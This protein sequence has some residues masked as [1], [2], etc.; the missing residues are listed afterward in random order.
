MAEMVSELREEGFPKTLKPR[1]FMFRGESAE[2]GDSF[3]LRLRIRIRE[4]SYPEKI[5]Q[6]PEII[7]TFNYFRLKAKDCFGK[8]S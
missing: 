7:V 2:E 8:A 4:I 6:G 3:N 5:P 1:Y